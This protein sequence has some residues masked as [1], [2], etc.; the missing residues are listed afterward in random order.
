MEGRQ[1]KLA[2]IG[3]RLV[4]VY[5]MLEGSTIKLVKIGTRLVKVY[6]YTVHNSGW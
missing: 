4:K 2:R 5:T 1:I 3:T 6:E